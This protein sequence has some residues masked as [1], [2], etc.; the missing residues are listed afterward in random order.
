MVSTSR[1]SC[2]QTT[3]FHAGV[4]TWG[5]SG[6]DEF[7]YRSAYGDVIARNGKLLYFLGK[8]TLFV[9]ISFINPHKT[10]RDC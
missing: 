10:C 2:C 1:R 5:G 9:H 8:A 7:P 4:G 3:A 6:V